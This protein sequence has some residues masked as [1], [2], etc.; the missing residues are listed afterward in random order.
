M[1]KFLDQDGTS[2]LVQSLISKTKT[3]NGQNIWNLDPN[4]QLHMPGNLNTSQLAIFP[5]PTAIIPYQES[6]NAQFEQRIVSWANSESM[7]Q[8]DTPM[9]YPNTNLGSLQ[10]LIVNYLTNSSANTYSPNMVMFGFR[11]MEVGTYLTGNISNF[12]NKY[13]LVDKIFAVG[14]NIVLSGRISDIATSSSTSSTETAS[15][16]FYITLNISR[17]TGGS[18]TSS[19]C[20]SAEWNFVKDKEVIDPIVYNL[21]TLINTFNTSATSSTYL[22]FANK[23][24]TRTVFNNQND[25]DWTTQAISNTKWETLKNCVETGNPLRITGYIGQN[26]GPRFDP[27]IGTPAATSSD[28]MSTPQYMYLDFVGGMYQQ[29]DD[30][31]IDLSSTGLMIPSGYE[32]TTSNEFLILY[33]SYPAQIGITYT[34]GSQTRPHLPSNITGRTS[35]LG[36]LF[37]QRCAVHIPD[38]SPVASVFPPKATYV[39]AWIPPVTN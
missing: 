3:L 21:T 17:P 36:T 8:I 4:T 25:F 38:G 34:A 10:W 23:M 18:G 1:A 7:F 16:R 22:N 30:E 15:G 11:V 27:Y 26:I 12:I 39:C 20:T 33:F 29:T 13:L 32:A 35:G 9:G 37:L 19:V 2:Y 14:I 24:A 31:E 6:Q 5:L 28:L